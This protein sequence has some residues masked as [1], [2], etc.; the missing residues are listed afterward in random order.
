LRIVITGSKGMLGYDLS[1][2][3]YKKYSLI[4]ID[5]DNCDIVSDKII[6]YILRKEPEFVF[7]LA[8]YSNVDM[9]EEERERAYNVNVIG[10]KNI[11]TV[12]EKVNIPL[13]L[14][15]TDYVFD[16]SKKT[17]YRENDTTKPINFYG[18]TKKEAEDI[19]K[20]RLEK[21]FIVRTS[22]L[23][24][25]NGKNFVKTIT[26][27]S[28]KRDKI[29]VVNDQKGSPTYTSDLSAAL[30]MFLAS[31][32]YGI[33]HITNKGICTWFDF[34]KE[35]VS[36]S[37]IKTEIIPIKS[38]D[39]KRPAKRPH[40]SALDNSHFEKIFSNKMPTWKDALGRHLLTETREQ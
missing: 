32:K 22:W 10:T 31:N 30:E 37:N 27:L 17:A 23:F 35:I 36:L 8:A 24:G 2:R 20:N 38:V 26:S 3:L 40:N 29:E 18:K 13:V 9:A 14:I 33:Y 11:V 15:S 7:H 34:A 21:F 5:I 1:K 4:G 16:G 39:F 6:D 19:V 12:C 28:Q 25:K